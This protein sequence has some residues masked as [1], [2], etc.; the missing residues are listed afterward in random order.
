MRLKVLFCTPLLLVLL[1]A[2]APGSDSAGTAKPTVLHVTRTEELPGYNFAPLD[3]MIQDVTTVQQIYQTAYALP[4]LASGMYNCPNG[5]ELI[6]HLE[7]LQGDSSVQQM[8]VDPT[9]CQLLWI[10]QN[11]D[12]RF[13]NEAFLE[14]LRKAL[15]IPSLVPPIPGRGQP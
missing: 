13:A 1:A 2:C 7:F 10:G 12:V 8:R 11:D 9:G 6:Y 14:L 5:L 3:V 4:R 15:G